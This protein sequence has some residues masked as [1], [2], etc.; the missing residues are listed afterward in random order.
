MRARGASGSQ[1]QAGRRK[2]ADAFRLTLSVATLLV[3]FSAHAQ[4]EKW[5][6]DKP[7]GERHGTMQPTAAQ[8]CYRAWCSDTALG[9]LCACVRESTDD[10]HSFSS[11]LPARRN[12]KLL[13][14]RRWEGDA[15]HFRIDRV[16]DQ[17][18]LLAVMRSESVGIAV[19]DWSVWAIDREKYRSRSKS[20]TT[21]RSLFPRQPGRAA[22]YLL[23]ARWHPG[24]SRAAGTAPISPEAGTRWKT[25]PFRAW[26]TGPRST[27]ATCQLS[28]A[29]DTPRRKAAGRCFGFAQQLRS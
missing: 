2:K 21:A 6:R 13:S 15:A 19:S 27:G 16:G 24:G 3:A 8:G 23:A 12:G 7:C 14:F 1:I 20:R 17:S 28:S 11:A 22:C 29:R 26:P 18:L 9:K 5:R 4:N 10:I 25:V